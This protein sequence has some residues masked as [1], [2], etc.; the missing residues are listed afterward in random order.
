MIKNVLAENA[1]L[2]IINQSRERYTSFTDLYK[3]ASWFV[4]ETEFYE[5]LD[6]LVKCR[7]I[8]IKGINTELYIGI[9]RAGITFLGK[10]A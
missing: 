5:E 6:R 2:R 9:T 3:V 7:H 4:N 10:C 1:V 8:R